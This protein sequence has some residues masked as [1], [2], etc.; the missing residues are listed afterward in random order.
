MKD[1]VLSFLRGNQGAYI[2]GEAMSKALGITRAGVWKAVRSLRAKGYIIDASPSKGYRFIKGLDMISV[3]DIRSVFRGETIGK[4]IL[5]YES[6]SSTN[7]RA[8]E[9]GK[10]GWPDG[11][12]VLADSQTK[13]KG[14]LGRQWLSPPGV[15]I[16]MTVLLRPDTLP[17]EATILALLGAVAVTG[18]IRKATEIHAAIKWPNDILFGNKKAGGIL[19]EMK[20]DMD[21]IHYIALGIGLNVNL[22]VS[23]LP[24]DVAARATSIKESLGMEFDRLVLIGRILEELEHWYK[25]LQKRGKSFILDEWKLMDSTIGKKIKAFSGGRELSGI[26]E[27]IDDEGALLIRLQSG[28]IEKLNA[29]DVTILKS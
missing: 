21:R 26:A 15:N 6:I 17:G 8:M 2:S 20:A 3:D 9:L 7:D 24:Q 27:G 16:Y 23:T 13:G 5:S 10:E 18:A 12:I 4:E 29:G 11:T 22:D 25:I 19:T 28:H 14:R 1:R